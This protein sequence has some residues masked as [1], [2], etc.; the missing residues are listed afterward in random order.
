MSNSKRAVANAI[1]NKIG[2]YE[3]T[4]RAYEKKL[5][6][7]RSATRRRLL[8]RKRYIMKIEN[9]IQVEEKKIQ[10]IQDAL[11]SNEFYFN[12]M[13]PEIDI[14]IASSVVIPNCKPYQYDLA[15]HEQLLH[16][17]DEYQ[18]NLPCACCS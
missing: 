14:A 8:K 13:V 6:G 3:R 17:I 5:I 15:K 16:L 10:Q 4:I 11:S 18:I 2:E 9:L 1:Q 7:P 12:T